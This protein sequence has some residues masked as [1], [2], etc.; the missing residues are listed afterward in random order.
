MKDGLPN[1]YFHEHLTSIMPFSRGANFVRGKER[2]AGDGK[3]EEEWRIIRKLPLE[4][5]L[6][7]A[8]YLKI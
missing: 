3:E 4:P 2:E 1:K 8:F 7:G 5:K 6:N